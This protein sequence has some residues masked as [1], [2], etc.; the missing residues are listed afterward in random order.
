MIRSNSAHSTRSERAGIGAIWVQVHRA[1]QLGGGCQRNRWKACIML[2]S[3]GS[4]SLCACGATRCDAED[5]CSNAPRMRRGERR[6][7]CCRQL[8]HARLCW[9]KCLSTDKMGEKQIVHLGVYYRRWVEDSSKLQVSKPA[10]FNDS[11]VSDVHEEPW[12]ASGI[13]AYNLQLDN[14]L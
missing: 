6:T 8:F 9:L 12:P 4:A 2:V 10:A 11:C 13:D 5:I 7:C 1:A 14:K 3:A